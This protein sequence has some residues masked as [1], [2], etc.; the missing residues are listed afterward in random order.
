MQKNLREL[1]KVRDSISYIYVE[2]A[3]I[4]QDNI[5]IKAIREDGIVPIP[6]ASL[7]VLFLGPGTNI[8]HAAINAI[9]LNG[10]MVVWCG[11]KGY[12]FYGMGIG[13]TRNSHNLIKQAKFCMDKD[14]HMQT[15]RRMY[16]VRFKGIKTEGLSL[17]Q[18]RGMEGVRVRQAYSR[19]SRIYGIKWKGRD[20]K[21][22][23][24]DESDSINKAL[25]CANSYLYGL[26]HSVIVALGYS[27]GL[28][29]IHTGK[30][31]SFVYDI[32]DLYK[33][34]TTIPAAFEAVKNDP[35]QA[36]KLIRKLCR[37]LFFQHKLLQRIPKDLEYVFLDKTGI[38]GENVDRPSDLWDEDTV[39]TGGK[40]YGMEL[41]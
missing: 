40:N 28:G 23:D 29:F 17:Q 20:Y 30:M 27:P 39:T 4:E 41:L 11:E 5:S 21:Q 31:L 13:E 35:F 18:I 25:S 19:A 26:C 32:A 24:W 12:R 33:A 10:C 34:E 38:E 6:I 36:E 7:T 22:T 8:T 15:V 9:C 2:H 3:K 1:P 16:A 14:L 37:K